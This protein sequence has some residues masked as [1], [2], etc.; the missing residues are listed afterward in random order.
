METRPDGTVLRLHGS[1]G[2][3]EAQSLGI[4]I[5]SLVHQQVRRIVLDLSDLHYVASVAISA[6]AAGICRGRARP[7]QVRLAAPSPSVREV[8]ARSRVMDWVGIYAS[9]DSAMELPGPPE[10]AANGRRRDERVVRAAKRHG[11]RVPV[12]RDAGEAA[13]PVRVTR[14]EGTLL[15][16]FAA[17]VL[18]KG[19]PAAPLPQRA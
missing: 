16:R 5:G 12:A 9:V 6:V 19:S 8:L 14:R 2:V 17:C 1:A 13:V 18:G 10:G 3:T 11:K 15:K 7:G 4:A